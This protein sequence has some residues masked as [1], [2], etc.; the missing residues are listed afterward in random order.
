M[1]RA[2]RR[3]AEPGLIAVLGVLVTTNAMQLFLI[4]TSI[5]AVMG[6]DRGVVWP[7]AVAS[8]VLAAANLGLLAAL[9]RGQR[10]Q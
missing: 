8:V 9:R 3:R 5:A 1:S 6:D 2:D 4:T 10:S 7:A